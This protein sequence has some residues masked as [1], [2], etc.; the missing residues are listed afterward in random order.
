MGVTGHT[1]NTEFEWEHRSHLVLL[2]SMSRAILFWRT[3]CLTGV[4]SD[5]RVTARLV[6][7]K[8]CMFSQYFYL[9]LYIN[10]GISL[11]TQQSD[12]SHSEATAV[13]QPVNRLPLLGLGIKCKVFNSHRTE[14]IMIFEQNT[15]SNNTEIMPALP[16]FLGWPVLSQ[17]PQLCWVLKRRNKKT[18]S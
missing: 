15:S 1:Y 16:E 14:N 5:R 18:T 13:A 3:T 2:L 11:H 17:H 12:T 10:R 7:L 8:A 4:S 9:L 6:L